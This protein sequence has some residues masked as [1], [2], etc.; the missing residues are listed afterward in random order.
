M[1]VIPVPNRQDNYS[2]LL[3]DES[4][5]KTG[6]VDPYDV[7]KVKKAAGR[8][9]LVVK[10]I[11]CGITTHHHFDHAGGNNVSLMNHDD[12]LQRPRC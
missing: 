4:T 12:I 11:V 2:Y 5:N 1:R 8:E 9:G 7:G 3:V 10:D 6:V